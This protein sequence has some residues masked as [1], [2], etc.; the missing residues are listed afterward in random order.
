MAI[1]IIVGIIGAPYIRGQSQAAR[2][3]AFEVASVKRDKSDDW[4]NARLE[5]LPGG[6]F[7]ATNLPVQIVIATAYNIPLQSERLSGRLEWIR[8]ERY[9]IEATAEKGAIPA[10]ATEKVRDEKMRLML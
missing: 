6:R 7:L 10:G 9:D 3:L 1:P 2:P 5:S 8:S 4:H